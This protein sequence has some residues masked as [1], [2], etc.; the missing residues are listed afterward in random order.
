MPEKDFKKKLSEIIA[1]VPDEYK[2]EVKEH[3]AFK[4]ELTLEQRLTMLF[5]D[6]PESKIGF[7]YV[8]D[9]DFKKTVKHSRNYYTHYGQHLKK[10]AAKGEELELL[11]AS[12]RALINYLV[13]KHLRMPETTLSDRFEIILSVHTIQVIFFNE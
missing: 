7:D 11:T 3:L 5:A 6:I 10:K 2:A 8:Y 12:C 13:L 1:G 4:N 9:D